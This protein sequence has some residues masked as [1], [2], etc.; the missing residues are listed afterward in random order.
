MLIYSR[1]QI[2][3]NNKERHSR[4]YNSSICTSLASK[5]NLAVFLSSQTHKR[6]H[7]VLCPMFASVFHQYD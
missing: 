5:V 1:L 4:F 6:I 7:L 2:N 3:E